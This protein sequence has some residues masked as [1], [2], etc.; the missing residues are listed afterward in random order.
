VITKIGDKVTVDFIG[1]NHVEG[2]VDAA[3]VRILERVDGQYIE[4]HLEKL[5]EEEE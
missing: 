3:P 4:K 1:W 2:K 5:E